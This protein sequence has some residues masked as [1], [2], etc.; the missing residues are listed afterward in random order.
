VNL[1]FP[2]PL[3]DIIPGDTYSLC[4]PIFRDRLAHCGFYG[5]GYNAELSSL[6]GHY[7]NGCSNKLIFIK[8]KAQKQDLLK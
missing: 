4:H 8:K 7:P 3:E 1:I 2:I 5:A 6:Q